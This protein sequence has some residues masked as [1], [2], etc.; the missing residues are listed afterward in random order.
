MPKSTTSKLARAKT[1]VTT[2]GSIAAT[3]MVV[4]SV[5]RDFLPP[6]FQEYLYFGFTNLINKFSTDL[7]MVIHEMDGL[8]MNE[9][10]N[11][12]EVYLASRIS[13]EI[14][15]L[16]VTKISNDKMIN[17]AMEI[18]QEFIDTYNGVKFKWCL[19][20]KTSPMREQSSNQ[21]DMI[22]SRSFELTFHQK[23][24]DL[25]LN[26][27][28]PF[29][30]N[31]SKTRKQ[32]DKSVKIFT[33]DDSN[34]PTSWTS[35]NLDHPSN[36]ATMA[37][38]SDVKENL[39]KDLDRFVARREY[40]RKIGKAWKRG[41]LLYGPPGTG[42]SSLIAAMANYLNFDIYD[43]ELTELHD[44]DAI[45]EAKALALENQQLGNVDLVQKM[46]LSGFLNF[47]DGLWSSCGDE[48]IIIFTTNKKDKLDPAL[49]RP[50]RMDVHI[51]MSIDKHSLFDKIEDLIRDA[52]IMPAEVAEQLLKN[53]DPDSAL[54]GLIELLVV[55]RTEE[56]E[57][58]AAKGMEQ[59]LDDELA[60]K[61]NE[62]NQKD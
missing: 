41:Y 59:R 4:R 15:R 6:E 24:K 55:K 58:L 11:A 36:F 51:H 19:I 53:D 42:K 16:K 61:Q 12:T 30:L 48:R 31:Y 22:E 3:A 38:D 44:R 5:A 7:T 23:Y 34:F 1:I 2:V 17:V 27:Y 52:K 47:V 32:Q 28:L 56:E 60:T 26:D 9:I 18:D 25:T 35:A 40:Y 13:I 49:L 14:R 43:L 33:V 54:H 45:E 39:I 29:I 50:G 37:M 8:N 21:N 46:T 62:N 57:K 10:Y 20:S